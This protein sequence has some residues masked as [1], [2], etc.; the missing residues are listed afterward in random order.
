MQT[1]LPL[2]PPNASSV[3]TE[4]D[5]L[6]LFITA[7]SGFFIVLVASLAFIFAI[8]YRRRHRDEVGEDIHGSLALG[9]FILINL[10]R[11][12]RQ[13]SAGARTAMDTR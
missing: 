6:Y 7:V 2:F 9:T 5:L 8:K 12:R 3:A 11:E 10:R 1:S 13:G 4:M